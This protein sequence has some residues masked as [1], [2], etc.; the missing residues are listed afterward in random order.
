MAEKKPQADSLRYGNDEGCRID[1]GRMAP[2]LHE[3]EVRQ[4]RVRENR[5]RAGHAYATQGSGEL[6]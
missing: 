5:T 6:Y 2:P 1:A 4:W 3:V